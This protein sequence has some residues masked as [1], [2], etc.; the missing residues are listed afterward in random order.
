MIGLRNKKSFTLIECVLAMGLSA[1]VLSSLLGIFSIAN[2]TWGSYLQK[3][4]VL[5]DIRYIL[6]RMT[7]EI[8]YTHKLVTL[9]DTLIEFETRYV[10]NNT[11]DVETIKYDKSGN[12]LRRAV[13]AG[14]WNVVISN[15]YVLK[16]TGYKVGTGDTLVAL[17]LAGGDT[18]DDA[19][20]VG[21][22]MNYRF[23][24]LWMGMAS[25]YE[26]IPVRTLVYLRN[27]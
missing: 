5:Q 25:T 20:A 22:E 6:F 12:N 16:F 11:A 8:R 13:G 18:I 2:K 15:L 3:G 7:S 19:V 23:N 1:L 9:N 21:I 14:V 4:G 27:L 24:L 10:E 17:N 26:N